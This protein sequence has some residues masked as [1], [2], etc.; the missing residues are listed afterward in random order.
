MK[1]EIT[2]DIDST[3]IDKL[4]KDTSTKD[5]IINKS[6]KEIVQAIIAYDEIN[7]EWHLLNLLIKEFLN[8]I[9]QT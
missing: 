6:A 7:G 8:N 1:K 9:V 3:F 2:F 5:L 4:I